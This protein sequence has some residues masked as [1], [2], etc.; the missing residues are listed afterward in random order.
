VRQYVQQRILFYEAQYEEHAAQIDDRTAQLQRELWAAVGSV[1]ASQPTPIVALA[2]AGMNDVLNTQ[3]DTVAAWANRIPTEAWLLMTAIAFCCCA[4]IGYGARRAR[5]PL[6]AT[7]SIVLSIAF[8][9]IADIDA[10]RHGL[11]EVRPQNLTV[12]ARSMQG[13]H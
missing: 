1:A 2:T 13:P 7:I 12:L 10:P 6:F 3:A 9:L 5:T 4:L 11:V 8:F